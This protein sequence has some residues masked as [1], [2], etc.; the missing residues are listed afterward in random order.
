M[1]TALSLRFRRRR[2]QRFLSTFPITSETRILDVGG[3]PDVWR[4][5]SQRPKVTLLNTPRTREE[6]G[7]AD[8]VA[9]DGCCLPFRDQSF[10]LVFS[11]SVIEHVGGYERRRLFAK[12]TRELGE[13][14]W[15]QTP[16]RNFPV[17]PHWLFPW[18]Q[19]LPPA[20]RAWVTGWWPLGNF[21]RLREKPYRERLWNVLEIELVSLAELKLHF[22]D[23]EIRRER[24]GP[25]TK[26]YVFTR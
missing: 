12:W 18:F 11:N 2:M 14:Y 20:A 15:M 1:L 26:S 5:V 25:L 3:T 17:E 21:T 4:L 7:T 19:F 10:D 24:L 9:G 16:N 8:W 6:Q 23:G 22:P 13:H